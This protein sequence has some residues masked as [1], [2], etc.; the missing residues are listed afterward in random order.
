[1][2]MKKQQ[3]C[4]LNMHDLSYIHYFFLK[5][6]NNKSERPIHSLIQTTWKQPEAKFSELSINKSP[7][8]N[9]PVRVRVCEPV[10]HW[11]VMLTKL[12]YLS[13]TKLV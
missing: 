10:T 5:I 3:T 12:K 2:D 6:E 1:M 7:W 9:I 11:A 13:Q 4:Y 8:D